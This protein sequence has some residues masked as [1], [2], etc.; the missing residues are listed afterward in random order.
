MKKLLLAL[1]LLATLCGC[2]RR[3]PAKPTHLV[4]QIV[5]YCE[6]QSGSLRRYYDSQEKMQAILAYL[7]NAETRTLAGE[8]P[9]TCTGG[10]IRITLIYTDNR[11]KTFLC[12]GCFVR[13]D[14]EAWKRVEPEK[15]VG[16]YQLV[17][18]LPQDTAPRL[19]LRA[20]P[21]N[22]VMRRSTEAVRKK[23]DFSKI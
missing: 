10:T 9:N 19:H 6:G 23:A 17:R 22:D 13:E 14:T 8:E 2:A 18:M 5:L 1:C 20:M 7:R 12:K 3:I 11:R 16:L 4:Q 21:W 15:L